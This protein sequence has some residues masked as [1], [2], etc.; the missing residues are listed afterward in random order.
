MF[1]DQFNQEFS[2][3]IE[4]MKGGHGDNYYYQMVS[5]IRR[6]K[7]ARK[8]PPAGPQKTIRIDGDFSDWQNVRPEFRDDIG[9]IPVRDHPGYNNVAQ[10]TNR[11]G[12]NDFTLLKVARDQYN[13]Y[14]Y[15]R[16]QKPITAHSDPEWMMLLLNTDAD[17]KTGWEGYDFI[18]NRTVKD[19]ATGVLE[20]NTGGWN[21]QPRGE[22]R[23]QVRG[24]EI[25]LVLRRTDIGLMNPS[26]PLRF[27]FKWADNP[28]LNG[29]IMAFT[30]NGDAAPNN[31][32]DYLYFVP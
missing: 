3:D 8:P 24:N 6:Y 29:D 1:V 21:W 28:Q 30:L 17:R 15:A 13:L 14:F 2:R 19:A 11:T 20:A 27:T 31:R 5:Y 18:L 9:D 12:R 32:F 7:G 23:M 22:V 25:E 4:P 26:K 16:T 10:Y